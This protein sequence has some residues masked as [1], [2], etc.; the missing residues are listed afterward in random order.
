[1]LIYLTVVFDLGLGFYVTNGMNL[2]KMHK[3]SDYVRSA[4]VTKVGGL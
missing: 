3:E 4:N 1:M 2:H